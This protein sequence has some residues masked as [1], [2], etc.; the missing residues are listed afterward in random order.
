MIVAVRGFG[1][2]SGR[3]YGLRHNISCCKY[4]GSAPYVPV[5][6][7]QTRETDQLALAQFLV[8]RN[9]QYIRGT[10]AGQVCLATYEYEYS[11]SFPREMKPP[12]TDAT[13][14]MRSLARGFE[15]KHNGLTG[16]LLATGLLTLQHM[17]SHSGHGEEC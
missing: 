3:W 12:W 5:A 13:P 14:G 9:N 6:G 8:K 16:K 7:G 11:L 2:F 15:W 1:Y 17:A 10:S 4:W